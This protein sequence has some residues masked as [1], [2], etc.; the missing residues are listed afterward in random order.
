MDLTA[1]E[2]CRCL[3]RR[4]GGHVA[5]GVIRGVESLPGARITAIRLE[6]A[7]VRIVA[8]LAGG[9]SVVAVVEL[10]PLSPADLRQ[11]E[12]PLIVYLHGDGPPVAVVRLCVPPADT[13]A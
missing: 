5:V 11:M 8:D 7:T 9:A 1:Q 13:A 12:L 2:V 4:P 3:T 10:V 6:E